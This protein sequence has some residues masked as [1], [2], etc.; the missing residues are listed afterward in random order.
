MSQDELAMQ[1]EGEGVR[2]IGE[3]EFVQAG[4]GRVAS[5]LVDRAS[6][7]FVKTFT[8][9]YAELASKEP[10]YAQLRGLI[11]MAIVAAFIQRY[12]YYG[13]ANWDLATFGD[14]ARFPVETYPAPRQVET[15]VNAVWKGNTLMTPVGGGVSIRPMLALASDNLKLDEAGDLKTLREKADIQ[16]LPKDQWWWDLE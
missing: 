8:T 2:L 16:T 1:L 6:Q 13:R 14:E 11:D 7:E 3:D 4:G 5:N 9:K 12:D 10:V 15:A